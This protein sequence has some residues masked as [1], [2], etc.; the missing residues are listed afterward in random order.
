MRGAIYYYSATGNTALAAGRLAQRMPVPFELIDVTAS[1]HV[2]LT[3]TDVFAFASPTDFVG[4]P[5]AYEA[6]IEA[7]PTQ[8]RTP[9]FVFNTFGAIS[10]K[11]LRILAKAVAAR[12]F[13]VLGG[14]SLHVPENYPPM[15]ARGMGAADAPSPRVLA[16]FDAFIARTAASVEALRDGGTAES[17]R[18]RIGALNS[19]IPRRKRT[20][21]RDDM[22]EK[23]V[24][25]QACTECGKCRRNCPYGAIS[26]EPRPVFDMAKCY[27]CWRCYNLCPAGAISTAKFQ[28]GPFYSGPTQ[29]LRE[30]LVVLEEPPRSGQ[31]PNGD[32]RG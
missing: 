8:D 4:I 6:F 1:R 30:K 3:S 19:L 7:L 11:T 31:E 28:G 5:R 2:D 32:T 29:A 13:T 20:T 22:G 10:G 14:H 26:L 9:A 23:S 25:A 16:D 24:D 15:I 27:G 12:G 17:Q 18:I 21:A